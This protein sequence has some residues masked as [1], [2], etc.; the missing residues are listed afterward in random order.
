MNPKDRLCVALDVP[1]A[2]QALALAKKLKGTVGLFKIGLELFTSEGPSVVRA[3]R[4]LR[5][6]VFLD[7]KFHDI[8]NTA[9]GAARAVTRLGVAMFNIHAAGG[10]EMMKAVVDATSDEA[11]KLGISQPLVLAVTVLT[12]I[13]EGVMK[14]DLRVREPLNGVVRHFA[15]IAKASGANGVI[16]SPRE[17]RLIRRTCGEDFVII[18][19]GVRPAWAAAKVDQRRVATPGDAIAAGA[20]YIVVGRP[21]IAADD[22]LMA[23]QRIL[24]EITESASLR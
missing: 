19:P 6:K 22:Q 24:N 18:A 9:A 13:D 7:L 5:L 11:A 21:I 2:P 16:A 15:E 8:P 1:A 3:M 23:S 17:I 10:Q 12:S 20:D 4:R 14:K